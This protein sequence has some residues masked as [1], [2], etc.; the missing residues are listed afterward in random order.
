MPASTQR[1]KLDKEISENI[2]R[3]MEKILKAWREN[4]PR[5]Y[6]GARRYD[7]M[8]R[9]YREAHPEMAEYEDYEAEEEE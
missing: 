9:R 8:F 3:E 1:D 2:S 4:N 5:A 7:E 6:E